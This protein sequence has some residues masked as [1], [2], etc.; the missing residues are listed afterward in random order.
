MRGLTG[1]FIIEELVRL[2][3]E[4]DIASEFRYRNPIVDKDTLFLAISQSGETADTLAALREA[5]KNGAKVVS[6]CNV[7]GSTITRESDGILYTHA[8]PEIGVASTKAFYN[9]INSALPACCLFRGCKGKDRWEILKRAF[10]RT[11]SP[12]AV[13]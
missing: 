12:A 10:K 9:A 4:V 5:K 3:V 7:V 6:I 13:D 8:G 11:G 2:P 1:K